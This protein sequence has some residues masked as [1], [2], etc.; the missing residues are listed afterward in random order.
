[1]FHR[2]IKNPNYPKS[3]FPNNSNLVYSIEFL[4][5]RLITGHFVATYSFLDANGNDKIFS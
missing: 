1:M 5:I 4:L 3:D 2:G